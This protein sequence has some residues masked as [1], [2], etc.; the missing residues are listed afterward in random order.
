[1]LGG[2]LGGYYFI[3]WSIQELFSNGLMAVGLP[4]Q[5]VYGKFWLVFPFAILIILIFM[6][7]TKEGRIK[8]SKASVTYLVALLP[9]IPVMA[10]FLPS[11]PAGGRYAFHV[12]TLLIILCSFAYHSMKNVKAFRILLVLL[13][14][15]TLIAFCKQSIHVRDAFAADRKISKEETLKFLADEPYL[16]GV[17]PP[18]FYDG[19]S[20]MYSTFFGRQ[21]RTRIF[22]ED[23]LKYNDDDVIEEIK[24]KDAIPYIQAQKRMK[25]GPLDIDINWNG[26][27]VKWQ[28]GPQRVKFYHLL[29]RKEK[30]L[31]YLY[32]PVQNNGRHFFAK[33]FADNENVYIRIFYSLP[34]DREVVSPEVRIFIPAN[35][36]YNYRSE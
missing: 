14:F 6:L 15:C 8:Y 10:I 33:G 36:H 4:I 25:S 31:Y 32:P 30:E 16:C 11:G 2:S 34:D 21:I 20:K 22:Y 17:Y 12:S 24:G 19:L 28:L 7:T 1:M 3:D 27:L 35:G 23:A 13:F 9:I 5:Y 26:R 29:L 18:W